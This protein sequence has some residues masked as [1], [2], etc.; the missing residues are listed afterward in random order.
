MKLED[1]VFWGKSKTPSVQVGVG[2]GILPEVPAQSPYWDSMRSGYFYRFFPNEPMVTHGNYP[3]EFVGRFNH[4]HNG[5]LFISEIVR[6]SG[7]EFDHA[8]HISRPGQ[9]MEV[10]GHWFFD[11]HPELND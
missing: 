9:F 1:L 8:Y 10:P 4:A 11:R 3:S 2:S 5:V 6:V 7:P